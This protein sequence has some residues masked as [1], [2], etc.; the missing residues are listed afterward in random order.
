LEVADAMAAPKNRGAAGLRSIVWDA[1]GFE[2][3]VCVASL[4]V[5]KP[6]PRGIGFFDQCAGG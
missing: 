2:P 3:K 5:E 6:P 1:R 4:N